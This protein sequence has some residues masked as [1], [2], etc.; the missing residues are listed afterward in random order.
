MNIPYVS[1]TLARQ[2]VT[3]LVRSPR[4]TSSLG[5]RNTTPP[6]ESPVDRPSASNAGTPSRPLA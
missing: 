1:L 2:Y 4:A 6:S 3:E 5:A